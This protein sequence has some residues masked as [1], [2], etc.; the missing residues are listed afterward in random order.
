MADDAR[1]QIGKTKYSAPAIER[2]F[3]ILELLAQERELSLSEVADRL[4]L[5]RNQVY[6]ELNVLTQLGYV[7]YWKKGRLYR[8]S[9]K[10]FRISHQHA[11]LQRLSEIAAPPMAALCEEIKNNCYLVIYSQGETLIYLNQDYKSDFGQWSL[12][13]G[14]T[15]PLTTSAAGLTILANSTT[16]DRLEILEGAQ[17]RGLEPSTKLDRIAK[18]LDEI[19]AEGVLQMESPE[20]VGIDEIAAPIFNYDSRLAGVLAVYDVKKLKSES[21]AAVKRKISSIIATAAT[22]SGDLGYR[23]Q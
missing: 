15:G 4:G 12:P 22:I 5:N 7:A 9:H 2:A 20:F 13:I 3:A 17:S 14:A 16:E 1:A 11:P 6:R 10:M 21:K 19:A 18:R 23:A 8:L